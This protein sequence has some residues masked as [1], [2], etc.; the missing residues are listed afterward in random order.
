MIDQIQGMQGRQLPIMH[1]AEL[2]CLSFPG[3]ESID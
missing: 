3:I 1:Y 2:H